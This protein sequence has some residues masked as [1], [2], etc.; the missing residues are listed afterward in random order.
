MVAKYSDTQLYNIQNASNN[1]VQQDAKSIWFELE[2]LKRFLY[3]VENNIKKN[4]VTISSEKLGIRIYYAAYPKNEAMRQLSQDQTDPSFTMNTAY[5]NKHTLVMI[6]TIA[7]SNGNNFD[8]NPQDQATYNGF[9][10]MPKGTKNP[11]LSDN[12]SLMSL[13][14]APTANGIVRTPSP[15][16]IM[17]RNHGELSPPGVSPGISF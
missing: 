4:N 5:E 17:A 1:A 16:A 10:N 13:G 8:F 2:T 11:L 7:D 6:P 3:H 12:Y 9:T 14:T 15:N